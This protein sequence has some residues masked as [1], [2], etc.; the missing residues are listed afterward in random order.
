MLMAALAGCKKGSGGGSDDGTGDGTGDVPKDWIQITTPADMNNVRNNLSGNYI[1]MNDISLSAYSAGT[2]WGPIGTDIAPF[3]GKF[4]GHGHKIT[5]LAINNTNGY[6][7]IYYG[8]FGCIHDGSVSNLGVEIAASG[9]I[10]RSY[11]GGI[12]GY[13]DGGTI[14]N[15]YTTGNVSSTT[16]AGGIAG[17]V[18]GTIN[19]CYSTG[20]ISSTA[21]STSYS[22][23]YSYAGGIAGYSEDGKITNCA[24]IN[25]TIYATS[26]AAYNSTDPSYAKAGRIAA[27]IAGTAS[28]NFALADMQATGVAFEI[29]AVNQ[30]VSKTLE[31][32]QTQSTYS[33]PVNGDGLGGLGW[34]FGSDDNNPWKMPAAGGFPVLYQQ[35]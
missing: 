13:V 5:G 1:L 24:A 26:K 19:N 21:Q 29:S 33:D 34:K 15:C 14:T 17:G 18:N 2:G 3:T 35:Q 31:E 10:G 16:Y 28:N 32:L 25:S 11:V 8:L 30:G 20:N 7:Y 9:I 23:F 27:A 22:Y 4:N 12:V 6:D